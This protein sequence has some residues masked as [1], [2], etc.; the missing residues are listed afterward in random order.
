MITNWQIQQALVTR[1]RDNTRPEIIALHAA[2]AADDEV[3]GNQFQGAEFAYPAIRVSFAY[4]N[5]TE[6]TPCRDDI[7]RSYFS[8]VAYSEDTSSLEANTVAGLVAEALDETILDE[9]DFRTGNISLGSVN[10]A[11]RIGPRLW[12]AEIFFRASIYQRTP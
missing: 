2:L 8:I 12:R 10:D 7:F 9:I 11:I 4:L 6:N 1:L 5:P 3:R